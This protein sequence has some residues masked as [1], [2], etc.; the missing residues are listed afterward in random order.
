MR[1]KSQES[2][3]SGLYEALKEFSSAKGEN[4]DCAVIALSVACEVSYQEAHKALADFG[5]KEGRPTFTQT[6]IEALNHFGY[7]AER[8]NPCDFID[9]FPGRHKEL[10]NL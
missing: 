9:K 4:N 1:M 10:K 6:I 5:R 7:D 3:P 2:K 8:L